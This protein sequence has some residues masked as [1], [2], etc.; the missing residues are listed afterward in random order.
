MLHKLATCLP[1]VTHFPASKN[2]ILRIKGYWNKIVSSR[3]IPYQRRMQNPVKHLKIEFF[4]KV[5]NGFE[6]VNYFP[7]ECA[8]VWIR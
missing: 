2:G 3:Q 4:A 7:R 6:P 8:P 5:F 1:H